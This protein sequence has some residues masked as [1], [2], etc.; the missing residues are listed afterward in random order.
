MSPE[1][2]EV[3]EPI[4]RVDLGLSQAQSLQGALSDVKGA[5]IAEETRASFR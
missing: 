4:V 3:D 2:R 5:T 1:F